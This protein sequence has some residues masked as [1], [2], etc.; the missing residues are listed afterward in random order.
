MNDR[1]ATGTSCWLH[2]CTRTKSH[3]ESRLRCRWVSRSRELMKWSICQ[4]MLTLPTWWSPTGV[5]SVHA[6]HPDGWLQWGGKLHTYI[7]GEAGL[8]RWHPKGMRVKQLQHMEIFE[9][10]IHFLLKIPNIPW[11]NPKGLGHPLQSPIVLMARNDNC[12]HLGQSSAQP[13][14]RPQLQSG[15]KI[16]VSGRQ[17]THFQRRLTTVTLSLV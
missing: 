2:G 14:D 17:F 6:E 4:H 1:K 11:L 12:T 3:R 13:L 15:G 10:W 8:K 9:S 16:K 7:P 5:R